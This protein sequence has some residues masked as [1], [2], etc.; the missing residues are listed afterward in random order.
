MP[1]IICKLGQVLEVNLECRMKSLYRRCCLIILLLPF[2]VCHAQPSLGLSNLAGFPDVVTQ[3]T[4][5]NVSGWIVN[6]GNT[7]FTGNLD[8]EMLVNGTDLLHVTN[9]FN[10]QT[11]L[12]PG[13]SV[14]WME[15]NYTFPPGQFRYGNNDVLIWP[16][17]PS[18]S[19]AESDSL[20]KPV[21]FA[22]SAAF[23]LHNTGFEVFGEYADLEDKYTF[24]ATVTNEG[25]KEAI[26]GVDLFVK[27]NWFAPVLLRHYDIEI[28]VNDTEE[29]VIEDFNIL[30]AFRIAHG[31]LTRNEPLVLEFFALEHAVQLDP[32]NERSVPVSKVTGLQ[33]L[34]SE[35]LIVYPNPSAG[36][37]KIVMP[38][39]VQAI[40]L[41]IFDMQGR[42]V[43]SQGTSDVIEGALLPAG[44]YVL[45][46]KVADA[47]SLRQLIVRR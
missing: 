11:P 46:V 27:M 2:A 10:V 28:D 12:Q 34:P 16:T 32:I 43:H 24:L 17:A 47:A 45:E 15:S 38:N 3:G 36:D 5:Y 1:R 14:Y 21:Y 29:F 4:N 25:N 6:S 23:R 20:G 22:N 8:I 13:D 41:D 42:L 44:T 7:A 9:N 37:L 19:S 26:D 35:G 18:N 33:Y 30:E 31:D 39:G 40:Q